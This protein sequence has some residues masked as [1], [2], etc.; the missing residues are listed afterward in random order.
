MWGIDT[1]SCISSAPFLPRTPWDGDGQTIFCTGTTNLWTAPN[2]GRDSHLPAAQMNR[3]RAMDR[4]KRAS[5]EREGWAACKPLINLTPHDFLYGNPSMWQLLGI[6][7]HPY[8]H[9]NL[10]N[11]V[12]ACAAGRS[13]LLR[14]VSMV[15]CL[16]GVYCKQI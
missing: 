10:H 5:S 14:S 6:L 2:K 12:S 9:G 7:H 3:H 15:R 11:S 8:C 4:G 1:H 16:V 13:L